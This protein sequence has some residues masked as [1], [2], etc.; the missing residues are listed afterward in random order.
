MVP[1]D[2]VIR[3]ASS[4]HPWTM[5][6]KA[7]SGSD[8]YGLFCVDLGSGIAQD[9]NAGRPFGS[10]HSIQRLADGTERAIAMRPIGPC[11]SKPYVPKSSGVIS[12]MV[13]F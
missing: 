2:C 8:S 6:G 1:V 12:W 3:R 4:T 11:T 10:K 5:L 9:S 7:V 13:P